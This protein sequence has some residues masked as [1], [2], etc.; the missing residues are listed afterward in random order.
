MVRRRGERGFRAASWDEALRLAADRMRAA[1]P[2]ALGLY[3]TSRGIGNEDYFAAQ[4]AARAL[5][6]NN[7]D[8]AA[9]ICHS[10]STVA[11]KA[12]LG[13]AATT[14]SYRDWLEAELIVFVGANVANNQP[15]AM[16][17]LH[18]AKRAGARVAVVNAC[19]E[20]GMERYWVP[21]VAE[22]ALFGTRISDRTFLVATGGDIAF[23]NGALKH[24]V[25]RDLVDRAF[26]AEHATGF[27]ETR[28]ALA[29]QG[30][31]ELERGSGASR[32]EME[33]LGEMVGR[34][35]RAVFVWSMGITQHPFG[36]DAVRAILNLGLSRGFVGRD[37]CGLMPIRGH[38]GVQG[39]AEMGAYATA[40][41]GGAPVDAAGAA[42]LSALWGFEVPAERGLTA[43]EMIDAAHEGRLEALFSLGGNFLEVL[44]DPARV[45][46]A[47]ERIPLRV[48]MDIVLSSQMLL[49][50]AEV[51][52]LLPSTTRY[53]EVGGITETSTERRVIF[54]PE[55][56]GPRLGEAR[57]PWRVLTE[58]ARRVRPELA[59]R[60][61]YSGTPA[62][63]EDI[64][65]A[66]PAYDGIQRLAREGD[67]LQLGG[68]HLCQGWRF[69]TPDG[70]A[71]FA[72]VPLP[73][74]A[75]P[76]GTFV[77]STRRGKQF[78]SMVQERTDALTGAA[79]E[80]VFISPV[81]AAALRLGEGDEVVLESEQGRFRGRL[82]LAALRPGNLQVHWRSAA[83]RPRESPTT[84]PRSGSSR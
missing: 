67:Q 64:A 4:K 11:L 6:T 17:Y 13:V 10:P 44:P 39:G 8:N 57:D 26:V 28:A 38:S 22:S 51:A 75:R 66:I 55:I 16:K 33:E 76:P 70:R 59:D 32:A 19:R 71:R 34:A 14:C 60:L 63:R 78:N 82:H 47:L 81:D 83:A 65:R 2:R 45:R 31:D 43:P 53:E 25:G 69:G 40:F 5:G 77:V 20:P 21:S 42:R 72:P 37:G 74:V 27:E 54:S 12:A 68:R 48:H 7:V 35:R 62:I 41:P 50:P 9:R 52:V 79:R 80:A 61:G 46:E 29:A 73:A 58:L 36:E 24:L 15:V 30:W 23:L 49:E 3:L 84:T 18:Y 1:P 56:P